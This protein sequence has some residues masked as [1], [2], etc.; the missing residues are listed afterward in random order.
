MAATQYDVG[1]KA[2]LASPTFTGTV[3][4]PQPFTIGAT[5]MTCTATELNTLDGIAATLT[6]TELNTLDGIAATLTSTE[7]NT[8]DGIAATLTSTEINT[9]DGVVATLTAAELN[10]LDGVTSNA[11]ELNF[12]DNKTGVPNLIL[13]AVLAN[14][15]TTGAN[16]NMNDLTGLVFTYVNNATYYFTFNGNVQP[17]AATTGCGFAFNHGGTITSYSLDFDH[18]LANTGTRSGGSATGDDASLGVSSGMPTNATA[19]PV[20]G[21]GIFI[22]GNNTGTAQLR[23]R[24]E[25]T[26]VTQCNA[27][28]T[29]M[30]YRT[31]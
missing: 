12:V 31:N 5:S 19:C 21:S 3:T 9:L 23:F 11:T 28:F 2:P 4:I 13:V 1:L 7:L 26:A 29:L 18:Q 27:G 24:S 10:I 8:L 17:T 22:A 15:V 20:K 25:T 6:P 16:T 14:N 30:V